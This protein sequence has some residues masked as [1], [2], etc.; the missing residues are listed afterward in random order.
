M[1]LTIN[2][3]SSVG[4]QP[5]GSVTIVDTTASIALGTPALDGSGNATIT[6]PSGGVSLF[7]AGTHTITV[8][9]SG[10]S[11]YQ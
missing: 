3:S 5:T 7:N 6:I 10:D 2:V 4:V 9:C 11:N 8:T 1:T